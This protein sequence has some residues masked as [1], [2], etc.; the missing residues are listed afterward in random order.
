[1]TSGIRRAIPGLHHEDIAA[2]KDGFSDS[3]QQKFLA[4]VQKH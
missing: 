1:M 3:E 4:C 2:I